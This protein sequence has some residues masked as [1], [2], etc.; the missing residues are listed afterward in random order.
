MSHS[1]T[2]QN[3]ALPARKLPPAP[4][5]FKDDN[6]SNIAFKHKDLYDKL[7]SINSSSEEK[8]KEDNITDPPSQDESNDCSNAISLLFIIID[9]FPNEYIWRLWL[10]ECNAPFSI[11][12]RPSSQ[13]VT[14]HIHAK[15]PQNVKS[16][17]VKD[18]L[19][20]FWYCTYF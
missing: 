15:Y 19:V 17:W 7:L 8:A 20:N 4:H 16:K 18:R 13:K 1:C 3:P 10:E 14:I 6:R 5:V 2:A 12:S 9:D 11:D